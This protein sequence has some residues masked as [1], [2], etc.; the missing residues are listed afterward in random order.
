MPAA[1]CEVA[2]CPIDKQWSGCK[3]GLQASLHSSVLRLKGPTGQRGT[4]R[5]DVLQRR[6]S[7][8]EEAGL[9]PQGDFMPPAWGLG[10]PVKEAPCLQDEHP[11][12]CLFC[13]LTNLRSFNLSPQALSLSR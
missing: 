4:G 10:S 11:L 13:A 12:L 3:L 8:L 7:P 2:H 6:H 1:G 5:E 9:H